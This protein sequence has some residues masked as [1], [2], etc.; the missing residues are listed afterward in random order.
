M[1]PEW[2][3]LHT[4]RE[5]NSS[6]AFKKFE[7]KFA[8]FLPA[9]EDPPTSKPCSKKTKAQEGMS[10]G[11]SILKQSAKTA[12]FHLTSANE[13]SCRRHEKC[14]T[15]QWQQWQ[16]IEQRS[17]GQK[18]RHSP[19]VLK[20]SAAAARRTAILLAKECGRLSGNAM[21]SA[22]PATGSPELG[23]NF[24]LDSGAS[25]NVI[26]R[27]ELTRAELQTLRKC[28]TIRLN[29]AGGILK[30]DHLVT[31]YVVD[32]EADFDFLVLPSCRPVLSMGRMADAV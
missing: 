15:Y 29:T 23:R 7:L 26:G 2:E 8:A 9:G 32:L 1:L 25:F 18:P 3:A 5:G 10:P 31:A 16:V 24:L 13:F 11:R 19:T 20:G 22:L 21:S 17:G 6:H 30:C 14:S 28:K 4:T 12:I 27:D